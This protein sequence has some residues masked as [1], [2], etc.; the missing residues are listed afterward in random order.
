MKANYKNTVIQIF[1]FAIAIGLIAWLVNR[2]TLDFSLLLRLAQ[3]IFLIPCLFAI[4]MNVFINNYRWVMLLRAQGFDLGIKK[5]LP[6]SFIGLFF[7][8]AMP[9]GVGGDLVKGYYL[10]QE[11][12]ERR[13]AAATSVVMDRLI[14]FVG[15]VVVSLIAIS[16][17][18]QMI[19]SRPELMSLAYAVVAL[20]L[21]FMSFFAFCFSKTIY[22]SR[23][24]KTFFD[25]IPLGSKFK[26]IY[27]AV[28]SYQKSPGYFFKACVLT[29]A[30]Q[31][32]AIFFFVM[33]GSALGLD[34]VPVVTYMFVIPLGLIATAL[35]ISPAG[36]GVGQAVFL[37]LFNW[38][39][40]F[41][42]Q[43]GPS[44]ITA[45]QLLTF[46]LGIVGA[47]FY[48]RRKRPDFSKVN[49]D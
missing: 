10:L 35:P 30:T 38:S 23:W 20:F 37:V 24:I 21:L 43:L 3:P 34:N 44:L 27:E 9:G 4:F 45:H 49:M 7:N 39:L 15:M 2:G 41:E 28:H 19:Q 22:N 17:N 26:K 16:M 8:Y 11:N 13:T 6:L 25:K 48:F 5:T 40:G 14:G 42:S 29:M 46:V 1:K 47:Y 18:F 33:T 31:V 12:P 36:I 32:A